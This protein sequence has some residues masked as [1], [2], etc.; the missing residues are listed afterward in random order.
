MVAR[1]TWELPLPCA[2]SGSTR[3]RIS[4]SRAP[5]Q[6]AHGEGSHLAVRLVSQHTAKTTILPC[7]WSGST[8]QSIL[9]WVLKIIYFAVSPV[10]WRT[11]KLAV[12]AH[13][14]VTLLLCAESQKDTRIRFC[15]VPCGRHTANMVF[16]VSYCAVQSLL[17]AAHG[18]C[19]C[20]VLQTHGKA[21]ESGSVLGFQMNCYIGDKFRTKSGILQ[22]GL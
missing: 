4:F 8:R 15:R 6:S 21:P 12:T 13:M 18:K 22:P 2:W 5:G 10:T 17:C 14:T 1:A 3:R 16:I 7:A 11:T 20:R 9:S 19:F